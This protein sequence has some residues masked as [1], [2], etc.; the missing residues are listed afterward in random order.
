[1]QVNSDE[2]ATCGILRAKSF[3]RIYGSQIE[4]ILQPTRTTETRHSKHLQG[5]TTLLFPAEWRSVIPQWQL[6]RG[7][8]DCHSTQIP[9]ILIL[10]LENDIRL[11]CWQQCLLCIATIVEY[12]FV[13]CLYSTSYLFSR[14][15]I[16]QKAFSIYKCTYYR[17]SWYR[18]NCTDCQPY[19]KTSIRVVDHVISKVRDFLHHAVLCRVQTDS[20]VLPSLLYN[21]FRMPLLQE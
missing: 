7:E 13:K 19:C 4:S 6:Q 8:S 20:A 18:L 17:I 16:T 11:K 5:I 21:W 10:L 1:M 15:S 3:M 14:N 9:R 2:A 12:T